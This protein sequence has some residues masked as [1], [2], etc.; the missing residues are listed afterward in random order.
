M[1]ETVTPSCGCVFCDLELE[2]ERCGDELAHYTN[3]KNR[4]W[5]ICTKSTDK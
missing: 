1:D 4:P 5:V 3:D 2:P